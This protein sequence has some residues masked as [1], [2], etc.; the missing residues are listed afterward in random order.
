VSE[1][2]CSDRIGFFSSSYDRKYAT[3]GVISGAVWIGIIDYWCQN[4]D[5]FFGATRK[6]EDME[7]LKAMLAEMN[8]N[9]KC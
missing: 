9:M 1:F 4:E 7:F 6:M 5:L 2:G 3:T 8:P